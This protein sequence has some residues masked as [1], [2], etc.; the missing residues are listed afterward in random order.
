ML[1]LMSVAA[2]W[3]WARCHGAC[4]DRAATSSCPLLLQMPTEAFNL[5]LSSQHCH[6]SDFRR[7]WSAQEVQFPAF[8]VLQPW[9]NLVF[10]SGASSLE[11]ETRFTELEKELQTHLNLQQCSTLCSLWFLQPEQPHLTSPS[12]PHSW[13]VKYCLVTVAQND[14]NYSVNENNR[15]FYIALMTNINTTVCFGIFPSR[16]SWLSAKPLL[17][18]G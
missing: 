16:L 12:S 5:P 3:A 10:P 2:E 15:A 17:S 11:L 7:P 18:H 8:K 6:F 14:S 4:T 9:R 1:S 13:Q